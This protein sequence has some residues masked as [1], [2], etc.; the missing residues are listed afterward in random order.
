MS[1]R[2]K[3]RVAN[4]VSLGVAI[5]GAVLAVADTI[6]SWELI[7]GY[8]SNAWGL[9]LAISLIINRIG[10]I[11]T[12]PAHTESDDKPTPPNP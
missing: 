12:H 4:W 3:K 7:P 11:L 5:S 6:K 9:V 10:S 8:L 1:K 2:F